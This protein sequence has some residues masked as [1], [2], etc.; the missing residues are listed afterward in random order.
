MSTEETPTERS[1]QT[2]RRLFRRLRAAFQAELL[3]DAAPTPS[4]RTLIEQ[5]A[6]AA[7]RAREMRDEVIAGN[8]IEDDTFVR[9]SN[10]VTRIMKAFR[11][12][13]GASKPPPKSQPQRKFNEND[14]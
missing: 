13:A 6:L 3:G 14:F 9:V 11:D 1:E 5:A 12:R 4:D 2:S 7:L 10:S 8:R